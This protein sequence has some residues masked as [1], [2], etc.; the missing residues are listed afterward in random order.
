MLL[1]LLS[2]FLFVGCQSLV[3]QELTPGVAYRHDLPMEINGQEYVGFA[4]V[5]DLDK[6]NIKLDPKGKMDFMAMRTC[7]REH[8]LE[9][10]G[11]RDQK[12][13]YVPDR[14]FEGVGDYCPVSFISLEKKKERHAFGM[15]FTEHNN[16]QLKGTVYCNSD[17]TS[18][19]GVG[20]CQLRHGLWASISFG[21]DIEKIT[22]TCGYALKLNSYIKF[23]VPKHFCVF[24]F[25]G[26]S[27]KVF[28]LT[29]FGYEEIPYGGL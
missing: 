8:T 5:E 28:E 12:V 22:N 17:G 19:N 25:K 14:Q 15:V 1:L 29:T 24:Y 18:Y 13:V 9:E 20:A 6:H 7:A 16:Y 10:A 23:K 27:G 21:E 26:T 3:V 11:Y 2:S 4:V